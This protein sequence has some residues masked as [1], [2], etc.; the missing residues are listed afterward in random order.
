MQLDNFLETWNVPLSGSVIFHPLSH[1]IR[2]EISNIQI[3]VEVVARNKKIGSPGIVIYNI[4][5]LMSAVV[6]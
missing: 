6:H 1:T 4:L 2:I 5:P 3:L